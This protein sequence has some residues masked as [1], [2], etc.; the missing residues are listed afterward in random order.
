MWIYYI[1]VDI[2]LPSL[3]FL[4]IFHLSKSDNSISKISNT[5]FAFSGVVLILGEPVAFY[6][7]LTC[8]W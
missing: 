1:D 5:S 3:L 8:I 7:E 6:E 4:Q 2:L